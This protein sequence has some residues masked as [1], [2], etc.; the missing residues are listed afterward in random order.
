MYALSKSV[1]R[2]GGEYRVELYSIEFLSEEAIVEVELKIIGEDTTESYVGE[3]VIERDDEEIARGA[4]INQ[5]TKEATIEAIEQR[6]I[7]VLGYN[8]T[9]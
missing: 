1:L 9:A 3:Y 4:V 7:E 6:A 8:E 2:V 5:P